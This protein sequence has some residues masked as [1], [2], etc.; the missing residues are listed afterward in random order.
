MFINFDNINFETPIKIHSD[1]IKGMKRPGKIMYSC[2]NLFYLEGVSEI[3]MIYSELP[4]ILKVQGTPPR[5]QYLPSSYINSL[6]YTYT[7]Y[8]CASKCLV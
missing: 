4:Q 8:S 1:L 6:V 2:N 5:N 7:Y 3:D